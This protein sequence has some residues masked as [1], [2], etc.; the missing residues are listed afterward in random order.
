MAPLR[1]GVAA[2]LLLLGL[3]GAFVLS[4]VET[5]TGPYHCGSWSDPTVTDEDVAELAPFSAGALED[6]QNE[7]EETHW[8]MMGLSALAAG[9]GLV[10]GVAAWL[11]T[12][13]FAA[14]VR[15]PSST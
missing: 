13:L 10:G 8:F 3:A 9:V 5:T 15:Q 4:Q 2:A 12:P 11:V 1:V 14:R 6:I 7:C